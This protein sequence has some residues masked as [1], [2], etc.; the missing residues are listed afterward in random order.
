[1]PLQARTI[2]KL[3]RECF[4][5]TE[6]MVVSADSRAR[7]VADTRA[8]LGRFPDLDIKDYAYMREEEKGKL[9]CPFVFRDSEPHSYYHV[10]SFRL[11]LDEGNRL[12][13]E[14]TRYRGGAALVSDLDEVVDFVRAT[15]DHAVRPVAH[16]GPAL[17]MGEGAHDLS[18]RHVRSQPPGAADSVGRDQAEPATA[19]G[20]RWLGVDTPAFR[21]IPFLH[22]FSPVRC[23]SLAKHHASGM[24]VP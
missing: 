10:N 12:T 15:V 4:A 13:I 6:P 20:R 2:D 18:R 22:V 24:P 17:V 23:A 16:A 9:I 8:R 11:V 14:C 21:Q 5:G 7:I 1:M 19:V 3:L